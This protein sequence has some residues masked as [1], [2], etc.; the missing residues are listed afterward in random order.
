ML[1]CFILQKII[2]KRVNI[3]FF[4]LKK[5]QSQVMCDLTK[6]TTLLIITMR[7]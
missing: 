2:N 7:D 1:E 6:I 5:S 3:I 4:A